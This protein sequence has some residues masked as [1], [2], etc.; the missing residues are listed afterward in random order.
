[1]IRVKI[2]DDL[3][4]AGKAITILDVQENYYRQGKFVDGNLKFENVEKGQYLNPSLVLHQHQ[5]EE[6]LHALAQGLAEAGYLP[7]ISRDKESELNATKHHLE[8]M[9][10]LVFNGKPPA[11]K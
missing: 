7:D 5:G 3:D 1:M 10:N 11:N 2:S 4:Y 6:F 8:D 9:R